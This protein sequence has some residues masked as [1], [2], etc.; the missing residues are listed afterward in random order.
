[1]KFRL[2][3]RVFIAPTT[4]EAGSV[5]EYHGPIGIAF[6][7]V[8]EEAQE[9]WDE[10]AKANPAKAG[11]R[12][13]DELPVVDTPDPVLIEAPPVETEPT[14]APQLGAPQKAQPGPTDGGKVLPV[15]GLAKPL[16][17]VEKPTEKA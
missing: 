14:T 13:F 15:P 8:D 12:P 10:W 5:I 4:F 7:P 3:T 9:K 1:M 11:F 2:N 17:K 6:D 16:P